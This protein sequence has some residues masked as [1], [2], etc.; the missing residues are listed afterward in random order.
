M[1][2]EK[3]DSKKKTGLMHK[4][5]MSKSGSGKKSE[6]NPTVSH[7]SREIEVFKDLKKG[8]CFELFFELE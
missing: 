7:V 6:T 8:A 3:S 2:V 5:S 4:L 1:K